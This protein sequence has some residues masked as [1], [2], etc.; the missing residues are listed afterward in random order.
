MQELVRMYRR[1]AITCREFVDGELIIK[2][3]KDFKS[4]LFLKHGPN[5]D[6]LK[7]VDMFEGSLKEFYCIFS[8]LIF[9]Y[10]FFRY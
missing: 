4:I 10:S 2:L 3:E 8:L 1:G 7:A 6:F 9:V 5:P